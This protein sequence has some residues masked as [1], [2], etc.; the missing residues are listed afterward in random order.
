MALRHCALDP[1]RRDESNSMCF[2]MS[3]RSW[4]TSSGWSFRREVI[5]QICGSIDLFKKKSRG[6]VDRTDCRRPCVSGD[7]TG[8]SEGNALPA[9]CSKHASLPNALVVSY[10]YV[11]G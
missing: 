3:N 9:G 7:L 5:F 8:S 4:A 10:V 2:N 11:T 1:S 6:L